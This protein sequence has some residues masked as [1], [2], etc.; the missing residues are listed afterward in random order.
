[1]TKAA[2]EHDAKLLEK[3]AGWAS[4]YVATVRPTVT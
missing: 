2:Y 1:M 4:T 3:A